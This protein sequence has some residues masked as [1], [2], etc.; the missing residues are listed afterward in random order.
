MH[1]I[2]A[3]IGWKDMQEI[4][5]RSGIQSTTID[6]HKLDHPGDC[7]EQTLQLLRTWVESQG[8]KAPEN[9]IQTLQKSGKKLQAE[10]V[11]KIL[12]V[13]LSA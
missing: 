3:A 5:M 10:K 8:K 7:Q 6:S 1:D 13:N 11:A 4:A 9:L 12:S 2:A